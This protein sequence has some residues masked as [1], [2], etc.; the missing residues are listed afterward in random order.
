MKPIQWVQFSWDLSKPL[1]SAPLLPPAFSIRRATAGDQEVICTLVRSS[2]TLDSEWNPYYTEIHPI[3]DKALGDIFPER[4]EPF[5]LVLSHGGRII[6]ASGLS[7]DLEAYNHLLTG[8]CI[9][10]EYRN[11]GLASL[12]L[13]ESLT[14]LRD[15]GIAIARGNTKAI[16]T[17][18]QFIYTKFGSM[19]AIVN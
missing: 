17:C 19:R 13:A 6:G 16:S 3:L 12:L 9:S 10:M 7:A 15:A 1:P 18:G 2:F 11:R 8:P 4:G 14:A 5:C